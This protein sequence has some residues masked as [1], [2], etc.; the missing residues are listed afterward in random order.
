M[1]W[2]FL[3]ALFHKRTPNQRPSVA[4]CHL[5]SLQFVG[6]IQNESAFCS[7]FTK[8][9]APLVIFCRRCL[10]TSKDVYFLF[11]TDEVFKTQLRNEVR[12][13]EICSILTC[14]KPV[15]FSRGFRAITLFCFASFCSQRNGI[16]RKR[17]QVVLSRFLEG[18]RLDSPFGQ[19]FLWLFGISALIQLAFVNFHSFKVSMGIASNILWLATG[20]YAG[21]YFNQN[22][23]LPRLPSVQELGNT[24]QGYLESKQKEK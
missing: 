5:R 10:C 4:T 19:L 22:Y 12:G 24:I 21:V 11:S 16:Y 1:E 18:F 3:R 7:R 2:S 17:K 14:Y 6:H 8:N 23:E 15:L 9:E 13:F 20:A